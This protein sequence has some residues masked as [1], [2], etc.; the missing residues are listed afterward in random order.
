VTGLQI[1]PRRHRGIPVLSLQG[2]LDLAGATALLTTVAELARA[3]SRSLICDLAAM[4]DVS[5]DRMLTVFPAAAR[6]IGAWPGHTLHLVGASPRIDHRLHRLRISRFLPVHRTL[7]EALP[8]AWSEGEATYRELMLVPDT[9]SPALARRCLA[10]LPPARPQPWPVGAD[11]VVSEL[12]TNA[13][14]HVRAPFTLT[15]AGRPDELLIGVTDESRQE[16]VLRRPPA[17]AGGGRG[18][19]LVAALSTAWGVRLVHRGGKTVWARMSL[20]ATPQAG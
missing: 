1:T 7:A 6:R 12:T 8:L 20:T 5:H 11:V 3:G 13:V 18:V 17:D 15:L 14:R 2:R 9:R 16:P 4:D 10:M 19:Q